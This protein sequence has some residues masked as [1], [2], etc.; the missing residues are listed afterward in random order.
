MDCFQCRTVTL[1]TDVMRVDGAVFR[2]GEEFTIVREYLTTGLGD[3][4]RVTFALA[5]HDGVIVLPCVP[6]GML[7][8]TG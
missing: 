8:E 7:M 1:T 6:S 3:R 4:D 5:A 2:A